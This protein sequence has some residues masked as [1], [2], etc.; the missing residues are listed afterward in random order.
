MSLDDKRR[1]WTLPVVGAAQLMVVLDGT[2]V[3]IA[4]PSA[5]RTLGMTD[6]ARH[7]VITAY[8]LAF[9]GLLLIGGRVG[10]ALGHRRTFLI[11][12]AGFAVA[13]A[14][15]GAAVAPWMLFAARTLQGVFAA[16]LAPAGLSILVTA[17]SDPRARGRAF[18]VYAAVGAMGSA[19]GLLAGGLLA[20]YATWRWCL[21]INVPVALLTAV[22][23]T[24]LVHRDHP[25]RD[26]RRLD[27]P[28]AILSAAGFATVVYG[29]N[30]AESRG[31]TAPPVLALLAAGIALLTAFVAV[32]LRTPNPLLPMRILRHRARAGA[33]LSVTLLF[34]AMIGCYL[35]LT[36]YTQTI[37]GYTPIR[38]GLALIINAGAAL[39]GATLIAGRLHTRVPP[40]AIIVPGLLST[41]AGMAVL[42]RLTA[43]S[44]HI[45]AL[46]L[47]PALL[48][49]GLGLGCVMPP[50]AS[51]ATAHLPPQDIGAA[52]ATYNAAQQVG[53]AL[54]TVL[55]NTIATSIATANLTP[56]THTTRTAATIHGYTT[57]LTV[58]TALLLT[59]ACLAA[60]LT[61]ARKQRTSHE[62]AQ[63]PTATPE[64]GQQ[65][66]RRAK[67]RA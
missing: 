40:A 63:D 28:G 34:A 18:G 23:A 67:S 24:L 4:L 45:L 55:L 56:P 52:S 20:E 38:A 8:A 14:L 17:F 39:V 64:T 25:T 6:A 65:H 29:F 12:L 31:W 41:A 10:A 62:N 47:I 21:Y 33:F 50:T 54:G 59:A 16:A 32:E 11:G 3:N 35:F 46:Y 49:T 42:T 44:T 1:W 15:G 2:I 43:H 37:L 13:S 26:R 60:P 27:V 9:G 36:Y 61:T 51:L 48:L 58:S 5:Q 22:G 57:A 53:G 7:W 19:V 30:L 66:E